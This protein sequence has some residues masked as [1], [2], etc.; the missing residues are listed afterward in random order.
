M[1]V[2]LLHQKD[3]IIRI[4]TKATF[5]KYANIF[6]LFHVIK[7]S[8]PLYIYIASNYARYILKFR[9]M[10]RETDVRHSA[11]QLV[12]CTGEYILLI[13]PLYSSTKIC[14]KTYVHPKLN[15]LITTHRT[16]TQTVSQP[17]RNT[18]YITR[19]RSVDRIEY[20]RQKIVSFEAIID[21]RER[22][23]ESE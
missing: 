23:S 20:K 17:F 22:E 8:K 11:I 21:E 14:Y 19:N 3:I 6:Y 7:I 13:R 18:L 12:E 1:F 4:T 5:D 15:S 9:I 10:R 16:R 2:Q